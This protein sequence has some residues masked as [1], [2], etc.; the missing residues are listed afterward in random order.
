MSK[1]I[2]SAAGSH[3]SPF[4]EIKRFTD[5]G[6]EYWSSR[7]FSEVLGY[8]DYDNFKAVIEKAKLA[9][10]N[11]GHDT[12]DHFRDVTE[13]VKIG[14]GATRSIKTVFMSRYACYLAIQNADPKKEIVAQ[15]QTYFAVQT[16]RQELDDKRIEDDLVEDE[17]RLDLRNKIRQHNSQLADAAKDA[18]VVEA[19]DY[20]IFQNHGYM[21]LYGGLKVGDIHQRK[22]LKKVRKF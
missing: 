17:Q 16:R 9:C 20:A 11:S 2:R 10:F 13:M 4:E 18:G 21:G 7:E 1:K 6:S 15:G 8:G 12:E 14:S 5:D 3:I 22:G 19:V